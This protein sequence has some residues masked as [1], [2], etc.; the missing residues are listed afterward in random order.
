[1]AQPRTV[2]DEEIEAFV[3]Q[4]P[5]VIRRQISQEFLSAEIWSK[6]EPEIE[7]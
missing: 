1:M 2:T 7:D 6:K 5:S 3:A 4:G